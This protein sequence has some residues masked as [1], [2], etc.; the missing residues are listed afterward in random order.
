MDTLPDTPVLREKLAAIIARTC[1]CEPAPLLDNHAF[2]SVIEQFDSLAILEILLEIETEF[3]LST[4]E[5]LPAEHHVGA[6]EF[7]SVFPRN[8]DDLAACM[9]QVHARRPANTTQVSP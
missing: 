4:D 6:Q 8:L 3:G 9:R 5:M 1:R 7:T 2:A